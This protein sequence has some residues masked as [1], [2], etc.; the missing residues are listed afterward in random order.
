MDTHVWIH[1][2]AMDE[3]HTHDLDGT[4]VHLGLLHTG[5]MSGIVEPVL[6]LTDG[7]ILWLGVGGDVLGYRWSSNQSYCIGSVAGPSHSSYIWR[8]REL[9]LKFLSN[10]SSCGIRSVFDHMLFIHIS[11]LLSA[12]VIKFGAQ[13]FSYSFHTLARNYWDSVVSHCGMRELN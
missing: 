9:F 3:R 10:M 12:T 1:F 6:S 2:F 7:N 13:L 8:Q 11:Q 5:H 4:E